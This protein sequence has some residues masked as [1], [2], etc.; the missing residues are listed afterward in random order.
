M[1]HNALVLLLAISIV[2]FL[3]FVI[4]RRQL[5]MA[6]EQFAVLSKDGENLLCDSSV[7]GRC[8]K[9]L[10]M[11]KNLPKLDQ[12]LQAKKDMGAM[13]EVSGTAAGDRY[14]VGQFS[15]GK[16][17]MYAS[18]AD[19]SSSVSMGFA[20]ADGKSFDDVMTVK[21]DGRVDM[22]SGSSKKA[23]LCIDAQC[24]TKEDI[25]KMKAPPPP[26]PTVP[27]AAFAPAAAAA[28]SAAC[29]RPDNWCTNPG[30]KYQAADCVGDGMIADHV[31]IDEDGKNDYG[32][33][34][35]ANGCK[36]DW[37]NADLSTCKGLPRV[38]QPVEGA[39][40]GLQQVAQSGSIVCGVTNKGDVNCKEGGGPWRR[41]QVDAMKYIS[42]WGERACGVGTSESVYCTNN[43]MAKPPKWYKFPP[44][45]S[46]KQLEVTGER[47]CGV[48][49][50][51]Q[52]YCA[53]WN[54]DI[55]KM[56]FGQK[57]GILKHIS[58]IDNKACGVNA[59]GDVWCTWN[60]DNPATEWTKV[61]GSLSQ[62]DM[63][64]SAICGVNSGGY[65]WCRKSWLQSTPWERKDDNNRT[66]LKGVS[67]D[68]SSTQMKKVGYGVAEDG[69]LKTTN[70]IEAT[71]DVNTSAQAAMQAYR[72]WQ[73]ANA[74]PPP[75]PS[76]PT[77]PPPPPPCNNVNQPIIYVDAGYGGRG[78]E[79]PVG[80]YPSL[81]AIGFH[82]N[83][84]SV[85][86]PV[87]WNLYLYKDENFRGQLGGGFHPG[88]YPN[89]GDYG[90]NDIV[91]SMRSVRV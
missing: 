64:G 4:Q 89:L 47:L 36:S 34:S 17:R 53:D 39:P 46:L 70:A 79:V 11:A 57:A 7:Y 77:P 30:A 59:G 84:S 24:I 14:G 9:D 25:I 69:S 37:P 81:K 27:K 65:T 16:M 13:I 1:L 21:K 55:S 72:A 18:S 29:K 80:D 76:V 56:Q 60:I 40:S 54:N 52:I 22:I 87:G 66:K 73:A 83:I 88:C 28:P 2:A 49:K 78:T 51:D 32:I 6:V 48:N 68:R 50:F 3:A 90:W 86:V 26:P 41:L 71:S 63:S 91:S 12:K 5:D 67:L 20:S 35:R 42:L 43:I 19:G 82:D 74:P 33:I 62:L 58:V 10:A 61:E 44:P 45:T 31:C 85:K 75:P 23:Q 38:W 15:G 8:G